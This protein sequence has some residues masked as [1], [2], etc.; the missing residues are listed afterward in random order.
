MSTYDQKKTLYWDTQNWMNERWNIHNGCI[1]NI[2]E[3]EVAGFELAQPKCT[4]S[5]TKYNFIVLLLWPIYN[6]AF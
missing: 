1:L 3:F 2:K 5:F 6:V 4:V